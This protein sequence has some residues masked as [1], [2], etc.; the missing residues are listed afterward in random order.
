[1]A[2]NNFKVFDES[3]TNQLSQAEYE[4]DAQR[5]NGVSSGLARS[6]LFNK[7]MHQAT[8]M[9]AALGQVLADK[10]INASD[11][12]AVALS[13]ELAG[14]FSGSKIYYSLADVNPLYTEDTPLRTVLTA[15]QVN[16]ELH[17]NITKVTA[18]YPETGILHITKTAIDTASM[19]LDSAT[20][21]RKATVTPATIEQIFGGGGV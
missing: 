7:A 20:R 8:T 4:A 13:Q 10:G 11:E 16:S 6:T 9:A 5:T 19:R 18:D 17:C 2:K 12:D 15:M 3:G 1:M 14:A 21:T